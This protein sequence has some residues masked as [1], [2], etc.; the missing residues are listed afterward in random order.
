[1]NPNAR[2]LSRIG[3]NLM[4]FIIASIALTKIQ[5]QCTIMLEM[6]DD[7]YLT[8]VYEVAACNLLTSNSMSGTIKL[9]EL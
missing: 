6:I 2:T 9:I 7:D 8:Y 3:V 1:M 4:H 5:H